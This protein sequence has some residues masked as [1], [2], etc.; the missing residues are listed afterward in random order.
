MANAVFNIAPDGIIKK[1]EL[2]I[3]DMSKKEIA[4]KSVESP[5]VTPSTENYKPEQDYSTDLRH[6]GDVR[7]Y[8]FYMSM[9]KWWLIAIYFFAC[10]CYVFGMTF[11]CK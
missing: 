4:Q 9:V 11:P 7:S 5:Y 3:A 8:L 2:T 10:A 1:G 6:S